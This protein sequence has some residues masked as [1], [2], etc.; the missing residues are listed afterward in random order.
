MKQY[1]I[2]SLLLLSASLV[3]CAEEFIVHHSAT[4]APIMISRRAY[5][6][7][8]CLKEIADDGS[9]MGITFRY[10]HVRGSTF[11]RSLLWPFE[12]GYACEAAVGSP[13][14]PSG[15][16]PVNTQPRLPES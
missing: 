8:D 11:G 9:R 3:G 1:V 16:Y 2:A 10:V 15:A 7:E 4:G 6:P 5:A 14:P 12:P 13:E